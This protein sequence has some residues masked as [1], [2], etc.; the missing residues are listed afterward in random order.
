MPGVWYPPLMDPLRPS[1]DSIIF[2][3]EIVDEPATGHCHLLGVVSAVQARTPAVGPFC[4]YVG[5]SNIRSDM[6]LAFEFVILGHAIDDAEERL[7][8][9]TIR[10]RSHG[11]G[12]PG[13]IGAGVCKMSVPDVPFRRPG[14]YQFR[15]LY[16]GT[17]I[18]RRNL[19]VFQIE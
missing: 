16:D 11:P 15:V 8:H 18:G 14:H 12:N 2:C 19:L 4:F 9:G 1:V 5:V 17:V 10:V 13:P 7:A 6:D 3:N